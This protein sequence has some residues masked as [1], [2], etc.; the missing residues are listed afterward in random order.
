V[1]ADVVRLVQ[2]LVF[3]PAVPFS[4]TN[5]LLHLS[6]CYIF[7]TGSGIKK[8]REVKIPPNGTSTH[9]NEKRDRSAGRWHEGSIS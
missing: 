5:F 9:T 6:Q 4:L 1:D 8:G 2:Q 3:L 7:M